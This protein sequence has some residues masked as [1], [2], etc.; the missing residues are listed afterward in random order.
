MLDLTKLAADLTT[1]RTALAAQPVSGAS[2]SQLAPLVNALN[3]AITDAT[4]AQALA[5]TELSS[6]AGIGG[7]VAGGNDAL[8]AAAFRDFA[9]VAA[10]DSDVT[11]LLNYLE[12]MSENVRLSGQ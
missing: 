1:L 8:M 7:V 6:T 12:R 2:L 10:Q 3:A 4:S 5:E 9:V 11:D